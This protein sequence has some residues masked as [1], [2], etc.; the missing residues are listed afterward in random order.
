M[1]KP[2]TTATPIKLNQ[3]MANSLEKFSEQGGEKIANYI[4]AAGKFAIAPLMILY[5]PFTK[6][7]KENKKW[8]AVKQPVE[9]VV[10]IAA[11]IMSLNL[12]YKGID[13]LA[14]KG[15]LNFKL[16]QD[17]QK[18]G[19]IPDAILK[20]SG[21]DRV[22]ALKNLQKTCLDIFKDRTGTILTIALYV[23]ILA[24]SNRVFPVI[25]DLLTKDN[26]DE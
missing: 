2:I 12:L 9:A 13:K 25:A 16:V 24:I 8:A 11:Q 18:S 19:K 20:A 1:I 10:T 22:K 17:A 14:E 4:N 26:D 6:E 21:G 5:N 3:R 23:P 15:K 7:P